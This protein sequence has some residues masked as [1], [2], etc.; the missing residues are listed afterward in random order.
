[1]SHYLGE[2]REHSG[3][4]IESTTSQS[5]IARRWPQQADCSQVPPGDLRMLGRNNCMAA[6]LLDLRMEA[7]G[8]S[9]AIQVLDLCIEVVEEME[10]GRE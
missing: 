9:E 2:N 10:M 5:Q 7:R 1:M 8:Q 4:W 3:G 6:M